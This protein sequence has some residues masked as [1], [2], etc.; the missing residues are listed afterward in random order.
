MRKITLH[1]KKLD[2]LKLNKFIWKKTMVHEITELREKIA[3]S[4]WMEPTTLEKLCKRDFLKNRSEFS[5]DRIIF[6]ML[7]EGWLYERGTTIF[8]Y[9]RI[10][11]NELSE[12]GL[13]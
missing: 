3:A 12:Y 1:V 13:I 4:L 10:V 11:E 9:R 8:T 6:L 2:A 5:V 7:R